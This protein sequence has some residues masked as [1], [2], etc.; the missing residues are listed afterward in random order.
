[1]LGMALPAAPGFAGTYEAFA[2]A[3]L[4][5][6]GVAGDVRLA[7]PTSPT[8]DGLAI[9]FVLTIH[10]GTHL[11]QSATAVYFLA[12]DRIDPVRMAQRAWSGQLSAP[13]SSG[14]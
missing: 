12:V 1:M 3:G 8:L 10:W 9:A 14:S 11:V 2:R 5:L 7:G 6:Y 4:A 13:A